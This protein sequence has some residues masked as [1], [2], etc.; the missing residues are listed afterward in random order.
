MIFIYKYKKKNET[1]KLRGVKLINHSEFPY[2]IP[3]IPVD[4][5]PNNNNAG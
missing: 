1:D 4:K 5:N 2:K 3:K